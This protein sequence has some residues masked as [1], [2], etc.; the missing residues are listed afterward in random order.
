MCG[1]AMAHQFRV[2]VHASP[3][4]D[5]RKSPPPRINAPAMLERSAERDAETGAAHPFADL[6]ARTALTNRGA[7]NRAYNPLLFFAK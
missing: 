1:P 4:I 3:Q 2:D 5:Q 6:A 7:T